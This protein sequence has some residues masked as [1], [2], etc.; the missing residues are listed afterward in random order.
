MS[1]GQAHAPY[2]HLRQ[3]LVGSVDTRYI[4]LCSHG[5]L[6]ILGVIPHLCQMRGKKGSSPISVNFGVGSI[7]P[8]NVHM[9][10]C[11]FA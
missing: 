7:F 5:S 2:G 6:V 8:R 3:P 11:I 1:L 4:A 9:Y 10:V